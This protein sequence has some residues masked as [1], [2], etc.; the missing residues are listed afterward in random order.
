VLFLLA[1]DDPKLP[2]VI[3]NRFPILP[4]VWSAALQV[5]AMVDHL[6]LGIVGFVHAVEDV[7]MGFVAD[8]GEGVDLIAGDV[9]EAANLVVDVFRQEL[10]PRVEDVVLVPEDVWEGSAGGVVPQLTLT[11]SIH[12]II[13]RIIQISIAIQKLEI[14]QL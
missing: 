4:P 1:L 10:A 6:I 12:G 13:N 8:E 14:N 11:S 2:E 9:L 5:V 7:L 3:I